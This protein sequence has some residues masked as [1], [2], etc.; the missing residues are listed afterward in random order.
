[1]LVKS[2]NGSFTAFFSF[3]TVSLPTN[4]TEIWVSIGA[5]PASRRRNA[6]V[7]SCPGGIAT[8]AQGN[9]LPMVHLPSAVWV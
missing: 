7:A 4:T 5:A 6:A 8:S 1:M 2:R 3:Q 9:S